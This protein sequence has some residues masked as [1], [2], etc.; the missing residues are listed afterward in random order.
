M[1]E[2]NRVIFITDTDTSEGPLSAAILKKM[3]PDVERIESRG[4][5]VL[6]PEPMN[7]KTVAIAASKGIELDGM[8]TPLSEE[9]FGEDT[10]LCVLDENRKSQVYEMFPAASN[11]YSL[12][13]YI[14]ESGSVTNP[15]GGE[16]ADY[17][18]MY[19]VLEGVILKLAYKLKEV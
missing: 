6:F 19:E 5:V 16:L 4:L 17:G 9:D 1:P 12:M 11:V 7:P 15:D 14:N 8:S 18:R 3:L 13:E 2:Y 10:I